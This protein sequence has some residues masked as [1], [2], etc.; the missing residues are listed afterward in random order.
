MEVDNEVSGNGN[1]YTTE[2]RQYDPRLGRWK[3]LD[4]LMK[5]FPWMSPYVAFNNN[6]VFYTD[7]FG[8]DPPEGGNP[9]IPATNPET[10]EDWV[11]GETYEVLDDDGNVFQWIFRRT[12]GYGTQHWFK[13]EQLA[14]KDAASAIG[15]QKRK[16]I[17]DKDF[18]W[19]PEKKGFYWGDQNINDLSE[20][21]KEFIRSGAYDVYTAPYTIE[22]F[23]EKITFVSDPNGSI[24]ERID[25]LSFIWWKAGVKE[26]Y[27]PAREQ[28]RE[29]MRFRIQLGGEAPGLFRANSFKTVQQVEAIVEEVVEA[30][31]IVRRGTTNSG[32]A[33]VVLRKGE[34]TLDIT[35]ERVKEY[36]SNPR[37]PNSRYGDAV[38]FKKYGVPDGSEIIKGAGKG[39]KRTPTK[40]ELKMLKGG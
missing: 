10:G 33:R 26:Y 31:E 37:N 8:D 2:F 3:S 14:V 29:V 38:N 34:K 6:P 21:K 25:N 17:G 13:G 16:W 28:L 35:E 27:R 19:N 22:L 32:K 12:D 20:I 11:W 1:S 5:K 4:P 23:G 18:V 15:E 39:H 7:P 24:S 30:Y 36:M 40:E 9:G